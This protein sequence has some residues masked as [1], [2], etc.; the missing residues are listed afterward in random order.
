MYCSESGYSSHV[1]CWKHHTWD[2]LLEYPRTLTQRSKRTYNALSN[3]LQ[4]WL[5]ERQHDWQAT[6]G[7][8]G[9]SFCLFDR[10]VAST[11]Q[12]DS[13]TELFARWTNQNQKTSAYQIPSEVCSSSSSSSS[14]SGGSSSPTFA[15]KCC[16]LC[17]FCLCCYNYSKY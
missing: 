8:R 15:S 6:V 2:E 3:C 14:S 9:I 7:T 4:V 13:S 1:A 17:R 5:N 10:C 11:S 12:L 16:K